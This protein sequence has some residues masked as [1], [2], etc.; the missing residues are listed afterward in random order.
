MVK[1]FRYS[2]AVY[3]GNKLY[4]K[5]ILNLESNG[6]VYGVVAFVFGAVVG[7]GIHIAKR[8]Y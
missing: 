1:G 6:S 7:H 5:P 8:S 2:H 4:N 3:D